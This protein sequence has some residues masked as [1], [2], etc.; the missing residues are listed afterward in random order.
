MNL[1][2]LVGSIFID[3][4]K[5][6]DSISKT[7]EKAGNLAQKFI[8]GAKTAAKWGAGITAAAVG[9]ATAAGA[10]IAKTVEDTREYRNEM[11]KLETAFESSNLSAEAAKDTYRGLQSIL[12]ETDQ[13]VEAA[14]H[15]A[16]LCRTEESLAEW[17]EI[18]TGVYATFGASLPIE[19]LTEAANETA[20]TG[21]LTGGLADALNWAGVNEEEFQ[22]KLEKCSGEQERQALIADTL[23]G[24]Y[25]EAAEK[26]RENNQAVIEANEAQEKLNE[27]MAVIGE[28]AEPIITKIKTLGIILLENAVPAFAEF[29]DK[30][31]EKLPTIEELSG[32]IDSAYQWCTEI[33]GYVS[34]K[35]SPVFSDFKD[36]VGF[37]KDKFA[38]L[39]Q[40]FTPTTD[41]MEIIKGAV[42]ILADAYENLKTLITGVSDGWKDAIE[43]GKEHK[44]VLS[45]IAIAVGTLTTAILVHN[46][47][48][49]TKM[50]QD[51][52]ETIAIYAMVAADNAYTAA[53]TIATTA[54]TAFGTATAAL[55]TPIGIAIAAIGAIIAIGVALY[56]N[57]DEVSTKAKEI[58][59]KVKEVF[60]GMKT[61]T[62]VI[63]ENI[64]QVVT[65]KT[66]EWK[67][68]VTNKVE[69][70]KT[71]T[72]NKFDAMK[73]GAVN[74]FNDIKNAISEKINGA[75]EVVREAIDKIKGFFDFSWSLPHIKLPHFNISGSFSLAPP[76]VPH[77]GI[78]W[79]AKAMNDPMIMNKPTAFG[80]NSLGEIMAGGEAGSEVVSGTDTLMK[81]IAAVV[82]AQNQELADSINSNFEKLI[83]LLLEYLP[84]LSNMQLVLDTGA[85]VGELAPA[86][87]EKLGIIAKKKEKGVW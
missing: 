16:K 86:M 30:I 6:N 4:E 61:A 45:T 64:K 12:G 31:N 20:K 10:A 81:M 73:T 36:G 2:K 43:W 47:A 78:E 76:S 38:E 28:T 40:E 55:Q 63:F 82:A 41:A 56:Q 21:A 51:K 84:Q 72:I 27:T 33:G 23:K 48:Q 74:K 24:L 54:T 25:S 11:G 32:K 67:R 39:I 53:K 29:G 87:D 68:S 79:Y 69:E 71:S 19:G 42:D 5:A 8:E 80:I 75:K 77:F 70:I 3:N 65:N 26:Y 66:N 9:M 15:L 85:T 34:E 18:C 57:W 37:L 83:L 35:L 7:D 1:F 58:G 46:G 17:T 14:N 62:T 13:S 22:K 44:T 49:L 59:A 60:E 50:L 52:A